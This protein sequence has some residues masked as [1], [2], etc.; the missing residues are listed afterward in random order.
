MHT[1]KEKLVRRLRIIEG[2]VRGLQDMIEKDTYCID[3]I[4]QTSAVKQA[5][6]AVED[7]LM[8]AHLRTCVTR[9]MKSGQ[10]AKAQE[11]IMK[12]YK[13]KRK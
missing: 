10:E 11:E 9:Q 8:E 2:Q 3:V 5:L 1:T 12:V 13:L 6:T 4:T 7:Q